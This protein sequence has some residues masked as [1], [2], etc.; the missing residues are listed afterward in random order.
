M[1]KA[2]RPTALL[3]SREFLNHKTPA[4]HPERPKRLEAIIEH[5]EKSPLWKKLLHLDPVA[6]ERKWVETVHDPAYVRKVEAVCGRGGGLLDWGDTPVCRDSFRVALLAVGALLRAADAIVGGQAANAFCAVRPP[7]HHARRAG[8]MGF[9]V[10]NNVAIAARYLQKRHRLTRILIADWDVHHG[11]GTQEAFYDDPSVFYLSI[12]RYPFYPGTGAATE[13]GEAEGE[14]YTLNIPVPAGTG[15]EEFVG[16]FGEALASAAGEFEP[17]F[18]I[19]SAGY[20]AHR[21]DPLGGLKLDDAEYGRLARLV[22]SVAEKH[23][24]GRLLVALEGGYDLGA[25][26]RSVAET[27]EAMVAAAAKAP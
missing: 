12:H 10:F 8:G 7:G 18:V 4:W 9:C 15:G 19:V 1:E 13:R 21:A 11:N 27:L 26:A 25:L 23:C 22:C 24:G 3:Y 2:K 16:R 17:E 20:D 14:G 6:A 5:L